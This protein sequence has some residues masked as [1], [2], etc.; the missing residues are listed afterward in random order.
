MY[1]ASPT[2]QLSW[3]GG[4]GGEE[5]AGAQFVDGT[6]FHSGGGAAGKDQADVLHV[7]A[8]SAYAWTYVEGPLPAGS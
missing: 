1:G 3:P 4:P 2:T 7:A 5:H 8:R 6:V